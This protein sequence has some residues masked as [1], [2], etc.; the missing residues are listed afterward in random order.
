MFPG[1]GE[2]TAPLHRLIK[3][4]VAFDWSPECK[5]AFETL[6]EDLCSPPVLAF[7]DFT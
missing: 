5:Q 4:G 7:P 6:K 1:Y 3:K 2:K